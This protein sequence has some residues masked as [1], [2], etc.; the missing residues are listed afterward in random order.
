MGF[1][2]LLEKIQDD[3][4]FLN[5]STCPQAHPGWQ[6]AVA[7]MRLGTYGN[8]TSAVRTEATNHIGQGTA[9]LYTQQ[10]IKALLNHKNEYLAWPDEV[11]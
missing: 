6:L 10:V 3:P 5:N 11:R 9:V 7:L 1:M 4:V 2:S 8:G